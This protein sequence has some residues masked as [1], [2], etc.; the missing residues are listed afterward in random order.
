METM[1]DIQRRINSVE[2]TKKITRA[3][4]M[5]ASAKLRTAQDMAEQ[6]RPFFNKTKNILADI[7]KFTRDIKE[8][9]L[10]ARREGD[11]HLYLTIGADRGLCGPYNNRIIDTAEEELAG[12]GGSLL[13]IGKKIRNYF[14]RRDQ[15][16]VSEYV[17]IMDY[18]DFEFAEKISQEVISLFEKEVFDSISLIYTHF[19]SALNQEI[20]VM[21]LLPIAS[22]E[23]SEKKQVDYIYEP[24]PKK[25]LDVLL[26]QYVNNIIYSALLEAKASEFGSRM[27]AMDSA[28]DNAREMIDDLTLSYNRARQ[29]AITKEITEIVGGAEALQDE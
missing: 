3:M 22:P 23:R 21:P 25:I 17:E 18:P 29:A 4:K 2:N 1:R 13:V 26:P 28:T 14:R 5:V 27:T 16:I 7:V 19:N 24:E 6:A 8:H 10:L 20:K 11:N 15:E 12:T 9:P